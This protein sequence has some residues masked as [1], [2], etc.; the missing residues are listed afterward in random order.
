[1]YIES[2]NIFDVY[3]EDSFG[4]DGADADAETPMPWMRLR[5]VVSESGSIVHTSRQRVLTITA[6]PIYR[7][8]LLIAEG[9]Y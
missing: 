3:G 5:V 9:S 4:S 7:S 1:M 2:D 6:L 8:A